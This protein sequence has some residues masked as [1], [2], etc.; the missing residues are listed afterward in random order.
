MWTYPKT[1]DVIVIGAGHAGCEASYVSAK[2]GA[3]TLLL[4]MNLDTIG[5]L[6][7]NPAVGG[8]AKGHIVKEIDALGGIMGKIADRSSIGFRMLNASKGPAVHSPRAQVDKS[9]YQREMKKALEDVKNLHIFMGTTESL[10]VEKGQIKGVHTKEGTS[11]LGKTVIISSGTFMRGLV[12]LG[13]NNYHAGRAGDAPSMGLSK[14]LE[15]LGFSL[16]RLKTGTPPRIHLDSIDFTDLEIQIPEKEVTFSFDE[17]EPSIEDVP[18]YITYTNEKTHAIIAKNLNRSPLFNG[19]ITSAGPRYC[20]SIE[21]KIHRF[22]DKNRHQ[23]FLE[24]EGLDTKEV[25]VNGISTSLPL[26]VQYAMLRSIKGLENAMLM[27]AAYAIEYDV[28]TSGQIDKTLETKEVE[29]LYLA[30]QINGTT[31]YEEAAAQGLIAGANAALKVQNRPAFIYHAK[32]PI[33]A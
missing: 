12:H 6:S 22:R 23:I 20:P 21:D 10:I 31:G 9:A 26:D 11:F 25:Y 1:F 19:T 17:K 5:K 8:T 4:T 29:G 30:G 2:M 24:R 14:D 27:R 18:C 28:L 13:E 16:G 7:C 32:M 3:E 15:K 33:L